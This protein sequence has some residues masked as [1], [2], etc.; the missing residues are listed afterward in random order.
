M[1]GIGT[2]LVTYIFLRE[3]LDA[4][5]RIQWDLPPEKFGGTMKVALHNLDSEVAKLTALD[6]LGLKISLRSCYRLHSTFAACLL[7]PPGT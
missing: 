3:C 1:V 4:Y 6:C 2:S 5:N 7:L